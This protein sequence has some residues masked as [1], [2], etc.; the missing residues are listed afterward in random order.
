MNST[1]D[2]SIPS[3]IDPVR[4]TVLLEDAGWRLVGGR[5]GS[6]NR[7]RS[8]G[9][10]ESRSA[11]VLIPLDPGAPDFD[12]L[13]AAAIVEIKSSPY[14]EQWDREIYP[15]LTIKAVDQFKFR[16]ETTAPS[17]L[18][19]WSAGER[20]IESAR[21]ALLAGAK[22]YMEQVSYFGNKLG[23][24]A[25]RYL[26][27]I[28]M[29]Q[30]SPGSYIV[31]AFAPVDER[32]PIRSSSPNTL[33]FE[34][35]DVVQSRKLNISVVNALEATIEAVNHYQ[36][37]ESYAGFD[38]G[39]ERGV[40]YEM[41]VALAKIVENAGEADISIEW[42]TLSPDPH[43]PATQRFE[44]KGSDIEILHKAST[45]LVASPPA[46]RI[47]V[48]G[49]VHLLTKKHV[50]GAGVVGIEALTPGEYKKLR[51]HM[52]SA[53]DY[54]RAVQAHDNDLA[55]SVSG[56]VSR[57]GNINWVYQ[58]RLDEILGPIETMSRGS[59][60]GATQLIDLPEESMFTLSEEIEDS[61]GS[62]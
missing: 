39:I 45:R 31:T 42:D 36:S 13:L 58:A 4:L 18:I 20:L 57:E 50:G 61:T 44:L 25:R 11:S 43:L 60:S 56:N 12:D 8:P 22:A 15:R 52:Q 49:R 54:H 5:H 30:T 21:L 23:G 27:S 37:T 34:G 26:D 9:D 48:V 19:P 2:A 51:V 59:Y 55:V 46:Q 17:G 41:T 29:G 24:F 16:R 28:F 6:Y 32:V 10:E 14:R 40:S 53:E 35:I 3:A 1:G 62:E 33:G 38:A 47:T 7:F